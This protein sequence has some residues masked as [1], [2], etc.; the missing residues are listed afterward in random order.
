MKDDLLT[1]TESLIE[2]VVSLE[3]IRREV[4]FLEVIH[5]EKVDLREVDHSE[6]VFLEEI[7]NEDIMKED[8]LQEE[9]HSEK[10]VF[11]LEIHNNS[12]RNNII[13]N[14]IRSINTV[15]YRLIRILKCQCAEDEGEEVDL[16]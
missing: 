15:N 3:R 14:I 1:M 11:L 7:H 12:N 6:D 13:S 2:K 16:G 5:R 8:V 4:D 10:K 9:S